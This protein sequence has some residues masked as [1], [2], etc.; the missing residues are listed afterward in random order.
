MIAE[1]SQTYDGGLHN[2]PLLDWNVAPWNPSDE[3]DYS[4]DESVMPPLIEL[5]D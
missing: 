2:C 1:P 4:D 3:N 5:D